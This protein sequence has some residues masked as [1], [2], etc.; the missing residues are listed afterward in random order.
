MADPYG[1][2][3]ITDTACRTTAQC[4]GKWAAITVWTLIALTVLYALFT[5]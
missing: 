5:G 2:R 1:G 4:V 3:K